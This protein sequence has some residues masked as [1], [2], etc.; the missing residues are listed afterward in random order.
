MTAL[1]KIREHL[2]RKTA[3]GVRLFSGGCLLAALL[4][5]ALLWGVSGG[6]EREMAELREVYLET[7]KALSRPDAAP[8]GAFPAARVR[9]DLAEVRKRLFHVTE[10][11]LQMREL[12]EYIRRS[13]L[14]ADRLSYDSRRID[15]LPL[16]RY[17]ASFRVVG[18]YAPLKR[19][20]AMIQSSPHLFC[21]ERIAFSREEG[22]NGGK[23]AMRLTLSTYLRGAAAPVPEG[24]GG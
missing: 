19:L 2:R 11:A 22:G 6:Q 16:W 9:G 15:P 1:W 3:P 21:I 24:V 12:S 17:E 18:E 23:V 10:L 7:R 4:L 8:E 13:A 14:S 20:L 5:A